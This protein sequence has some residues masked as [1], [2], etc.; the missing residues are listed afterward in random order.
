MITELPHTTKRGVSIKLSFRPFI[1]YLQNQQKNCQATNRLGDMYTYMTDQFTP[2]FGIEPLEELYDKDRLSMLFQMATV[3][4]FPLAHTNREIS[5][6]FGLPFPM[7]LFHQS[8]EFGRL[9]DE[10]PSLLSDIRAQIGEEDQ[11]RFWYRLIL[12]R[13]YGVQS[14]NGKTASFRFQQTANGLT[15][16]FRIKINTTFIERSPADSFRFEPKL[17]DLQ[18]AWIDF[19]KGGRLPNKNTGGL[20]LS[21]F[22]FEGFAFFIVEDITEAETVHQLQAVFSRLHSDTEPEIYR[23]FETALRNLVGQP[24][25]QLSIVPFQ[26]V[27]GYFVHQ[28]E[29]SARSVFLRHSGKVVDGYKDPHAQKTVQELIKNPVP[30]LFPGLVG[31]PEMGQKMLYQNGFRSFLWYPIVNG[32][33]ALGILEMASPQ[34]DAFDEGLLPKIEQVIPLVQELLRYQLRQF[35]Q[36]LEQLIKQKF[37]SLQPSVEWKFNEVAWEYLRLGKKESFNSPATQVRFP[38]VY[39][40][41]GAIDIRNSSNERYKAVRQDFSNQLAALQQLL[42]QADLP[43][44]LATPEQLIATASAWQSKLTEDLNP[45][46][47]LNISDF[48]A[49]EVN[50]YFEHL[51]LHYPDL[52]TAIQ[53]YFGQTNPTNG[54]FNRSLQVYERSVEWLNTAVNTFIENE[55]KQLQAVYPHYFERYRTDGMEYTIYIG[56]SISPQKPFEPDYLRLLFKWQLNSMVEMARLTHLLL[57]RLPLPLQTTQLILAH[58]QAV[59][60]SFRQDEHRFDVEGSYSIR[61]EVLKKR[62]DKALI[63]GTQERLTQPDTIALVYTNTREIVDY[64]PF[65]TELQKQNKLTSD[66]EYLDLEPLQGV[67]RLKALRLRLDYSSEQD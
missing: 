57:P 37:T 6:A 59:D 23:R 60:I 42:K 58:G 27:N 1:N 44:E 20:T 28:E 9:R 12:E 55:E 62:I 21:D 14:F 31:L 39:P 11:Q 25:L 17:P 34:P 30:R 18:S 49:L 8:D 13:Y 16:Y 10:Y 29:M 56:Q 5:Y 46:D 67:A 24:D 4:V 33:E 63:A 19:A 26:Q 43:N 54:Q 40:V 38:Q 48:L 51:R 22:R 36:N 53:H 41:Y 32:D 47:E 66:I 52:E 7:T 45:E 2:T 35:N 15:K 50:P 61:Y 65:I 3:A 64:L